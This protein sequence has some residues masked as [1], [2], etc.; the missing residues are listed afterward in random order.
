MAGTRS[1]V[2]L[3]PLASVKLHVVCVQATPDAASLTP[4]TRY[5]YDVKLGAADGDDGTP[6]PA[7]R[8]LFTNDVIR[9][10]GTA[11]R[12][13]L[14]YAE[15]GG[16]MLPS[17]VVPPDDVDDLRLL[18]ASCRKPHGKGPD[19]LAIGDTIVAPLDR[20]PRRART[21]CSSAATRSTPTTSPMRAAVH[22]PATRPTA[23]GCASSS[24]RSRAAHEDRRRAQARRAREASSRR[25]PASRPTTADSHLLTFAE[26]AL[27]YVFAWSDALWPATVAGH[28]ELHDRARRRVAASARTTSSP[29]RPAAQPKRPRHQTTRD[30]GSGDERPHLE[31]ST[32]ALPAVRRLLANVADAD[33]LRR[34]RDHRRLEPQPRVDPAHPGSREGGPDGDQG[35]TALARAVL[36]NGLVAYAIFQAWGNTPEQF[37]ARDRSRHQAARRRRHVE[38]RQHRH[39]DRGDDDRGRPAV[40]DR[41]P[42][43]R[44]ATRARWT[45]HYRT[46]LGRARADRARHP[47]PARRGQGGRGGRPARAD[48]RAGRLRRDAARRTRARADAA[49]ARDRPGPDVRRAAPRGGGALLLGQPVPDGRRARIPSTGRSPRTRASTLLGALLARG[50]AGADNVVRSRV[51]VLSGDVHHGSAVHVRYSATKPLGRPGARVEAVLAQLTSS[52]LKN[53]ETKTFLIEALGFFT[54]DSRLTGIVGIDMPVIEVSG[55]ENAADGEL[56][57]GPR[58]L[59]PDHPPSYPIVIEGTPGAARVHLRGPVRGPAQ[60]AVADHVR[61]RRGPGVELRRA[62][63]AGRAREPPA[64]AAPRHE[65]RPGRAHRPGAARRARAPQLLARH[66]SRPGGRRPQQHRRRDVPVG[67]GRR[68]VRHAEAVVAARAPRRTRSRAPRG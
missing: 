41:R 8:S 66:R 16:P 20:G 58:A 14:T 23:L 22:D 4:N 24:S 44:S 53:E 6:A 50:P 61:A 62:A 5:V 13:L 59:R 34:P 51:V 36:R 37:D 11:A 12:Q 42:T 7:G 49:R 18:H 3:G 45:W 54:L 57:G 1:T 26:Y 39:R 30:D 10:S 64:A 9:E 68:Q 19:A 21:S 32:T 67:R 28:P 25:T 46:G 38:R 52:A 40:G 15:A 2:P 60:P 27:M 29:T 43:S 48:L 33:G 56:D 63:R 17:F 35:P 47:H 31:R 55:W 65:R